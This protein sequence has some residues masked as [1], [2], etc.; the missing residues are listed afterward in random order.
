MQVEDVELQRRGAVDEPLDD[1]DVEEVAGDVE[2]QASVREARGVV[3]LD[4]GDL[5][6]VAPVGEQ[7]TQRLRPVEQAGLGGGV[8]RRALRCDPQPVPL[9][10][11]GGPIEP[12]HDGGGRIALGECVESDAGACGDGVDD[13]GDVRR[14]AGDPEPLPKPEGTRAAL[15]DA[16]EGDHA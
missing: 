1:V 2:H 8:D 13:P 12:Q 15:E 9:G 4:R 6:S 3:D 16:G 11:P 14:G 7:L 10:R 5:P